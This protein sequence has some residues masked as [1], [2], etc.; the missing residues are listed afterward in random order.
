M[1]WIDPFVLMA[2]LPFRPRL[3]FFGPR[4]EEMGVGGRNRMMAWTGAAI[5]YKPGKN[6]LLEATRK[7]S[8]V[9][10]AGGVLAIAGRDGSTRASRS[11][12]PLNEGAASLRCAPASRSC[13][14][15]SGARAGSPSA[16][17]SG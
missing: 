2:V 7:T 12:L 13:R 6:D 10:K 8:Q 5:P 3:Y 11:C 1:N 15:R 9:F 14:S 17:G 4:E 16:G